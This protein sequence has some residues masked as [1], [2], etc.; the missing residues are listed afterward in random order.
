MQGAL[1]KAPRTRQPERRK[2]GVNRCG[3]I[4]QR[5][6]SRPN[7]THNS[8]RHTRRRRQTGWYHRSSK[9]HSPEQHT[10]SLKLMLVPPKLL[11]LLVA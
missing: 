6:R 11:D 1:A 2:P 5:W 9:R 4:L 10:I 3:T 7:N 8:R